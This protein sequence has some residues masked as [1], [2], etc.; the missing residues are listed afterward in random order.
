MLQVIET[1][2][3]QKGIGTA[4]I[5]GIGVNVRSGAGAGYLVVRKASKGE[6]VTVYEEKNGW[7][8]IGTDE[9]IYNEPSYIVYKKDGN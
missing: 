1:G 4:E 5:N 9:W 2:S 7:L 3:V 8:R 6:K